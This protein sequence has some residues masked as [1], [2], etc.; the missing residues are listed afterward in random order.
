MMKRL[1][2]LSLIIITS[3]CAATG[4]N[5]IKNQSQLKQLDSNK[6][7]IYV[8]RTGESMQYSARA[9]SVKV[10]DSIKKSCAYKG[11]NVIDVNAGGHQI[12]ADMWDSPGKC[13]I[14]V[15]LSPQ[16]EYFFE[17]KPRSGN[18][19]G[20]LAGGLAGAAIESAGKTC[21]GA[22]SIEEVE[23]SLASEKIKT[24][25]LSE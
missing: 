9:V 10:D 6:S 8:F 17:V 15:N 18:L 21:G 25:N 7:R 4:N 12:Q 2:L 3:G 23:P 5:F 1:L 19:I 13:T 24:L 11:F 14:T 20:A 22:F 16:T